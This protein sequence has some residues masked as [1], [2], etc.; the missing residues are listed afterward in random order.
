MNFSSFF[1]LGGSRKS[2]RSSKSRK[3]RRGGSGGRRGGSGGLGASR[4]DPGSSDVILGVN[5]NKSPEMRS[6]IASGGSRRR[7]S[8]RGGGGQAGMTLQSRQHQ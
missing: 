4:V 3:S 8:R 6:L 1:K 5:A 7:R 2:R